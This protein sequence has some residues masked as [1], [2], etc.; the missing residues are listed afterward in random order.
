M[1]IMASDVISQTMGHV[2]RPALG[3]R[4]IIAHPGLGLRLHSILSRL[5]HAGAG[6]G[7][8]KPAPWLTKWPSRGV[9]GRLG[10][11]SEMFAPDGVAGGVQLDPLSLQPSLG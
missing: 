10:Q 3:R 7:L 1:K 9:T 5:R 8:P 6:E 2:A 11:L 4:N